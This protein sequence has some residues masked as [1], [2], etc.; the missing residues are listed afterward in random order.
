[1]PGATKF[2]ISEAVRGE[3][4]VLL[5]PRGNAFMEKHSP[6]WK[7]LA[8]RDIVARAIYWEMLENKYPYVLLDISSHMKADAIKTRFPQA[9]VSLHAFATLSAHLAPIS[10][11]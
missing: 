5:T 4:G 6:E 8:P 1:M 10:L 2:L 7:D 3:G 9:C 11:R